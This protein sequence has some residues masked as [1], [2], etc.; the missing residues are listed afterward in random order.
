MDKTGLRK[1]LAENYGTYG[2]NQWY[3]PSYRDQYRNAGVGLD[4]LNRL[5]EDEVDSGLRKE[6]ESMFK[7]QQGSAVAGGVLAGLNGLTSIVGTAVDLAGNNDTQW[8]DDQ[9]NQMRGI[10]KM[11]YDSYDQIVTDYGLLNRQPHIT[12]QDI[13]GKTDMQKLAGIG[14][15]TLSGAATGLQIGGPWGAAIGGAV[16]FLGGAAGSV[17]GDID[18]EN[19]LKAKKNDAYISTDIAQA[20]LGEGTERF[21]GY[22]FRSGI[23]T[24]RKDGGPIKRQQTI[25]EFAD[26]IMKR[27]RASDRTHSAG[28]VHKKVE[29]GTMFRI[30]VK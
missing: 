8:Y 25:A 16:G 21:T 18:A 30:K 7:S 9:V 26:Q 23:G 15:A 4:A 22:K 13:R 29:G 19:G 27:Q 2:A 10:G 28:L 11:N 12:Y 20:N 24:A 6:Y 5:G 14:S 3:G 17:M 1:Y